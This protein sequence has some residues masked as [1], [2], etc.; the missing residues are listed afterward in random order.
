MAEKRDPNFGVMSVNYDFEELL[1][2][3]GPA[4]RSEHRDTFLEGNAGLAASTKLKTQHHRARTG[5][6]SAEGW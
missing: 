3:A 1:A 2:Q 5:A 4:M 6:S